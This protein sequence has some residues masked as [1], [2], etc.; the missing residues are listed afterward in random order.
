MR[1]KYIIIGLTWLVML[2]LNSC[3]GT[4]SDIID[5][6]GQMGTVT[7]IEGNV[8]NTT[9]I[10]SQIW[11]A[12]NLKSTTLNNGIEIPEIKGVTDWTYSVNPGL[13]YYPLTTYK[14]DSY[15]DL[16]DFDDNI[17]LPL[18]DQVKDFVSEVNK[19]N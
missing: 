17:L 7:D 15:G 14:K 13:C 3:E 18:V 1:V 8:Y 11:M 5:Y 6:T 10:G 12:G 9:G 4:E 16:N 2:I 19:L